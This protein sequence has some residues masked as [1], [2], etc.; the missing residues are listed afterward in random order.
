MSLVIE[1]LGVVSCL[2]V[3]SVL[4]PPPE[5]PTVK[6]M[7]GKD[8][9]EPARFYRGGVCC[10]Q[11]FF[12]G[13]SRSCARY[14]TARRSACVIMWPSHFSFSTLSCIAR[15]RN[16][17]LWES[18]LPFSFFPPDFSFLSRLWRLL[19]SYGRLF[20]FLAITLPLAP[21]SL[22]GK[23]LTF[24]SGR[25]SVRMFDTYLPVPNEFTCGSFTR[26]AVHPLRPMSLL[27]H[28]GELFSGSLF[29]PFWKQV[30]SG[31]YAR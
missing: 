1:F 9:V 11:S 13:L 22:Q 12:P 2:R 28:C 7:P 29:F 10:S 16:F 20:V 15:R 14:R 17:N 18:F 25:C 6:L 23:I 19:S 8:Y 4:L 26:R 31:G 27:P 24:S 30:R 21:F 3:T 5:R